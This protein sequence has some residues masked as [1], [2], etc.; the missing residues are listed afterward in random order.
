MPDEPRKPRTPERCHNMLPSSRRVLTRSAL[1]CGVLAATL[2]ACFWPLFRHPADL[3]VGVQ[4]KGFTDLLMFNLPR[5]EYLR[6][7]LTRDG[8]L[9]FWCP[10]LGGGSP[11]LGSLQAA[12]FYPGNWPFWFF[13][14]RGLISWSLVGHHLLAA[15][16]AYGLCRRLGGRSLGASLA[17]VAFGASPVLLARTGEGH[18]VTVS[19]LSW[20]PWTFWMYE[21]FRAGS[22]RG[23]AGLVVVLALAVLAGHLQ[24]AFYLILALT[25]IC[26]VEAVRLAFAGQRARAAGLLA[27]WALAGAATAG[28][29]A[30][31]LIPMA[32]Y[33]RQ[34]AGKARLAGEDLTGVPGVANL[35]QF[36][37]PFA[38]GGPANYRGPGVWYWE[39]ICYFGLVPLALAVLGL[40]VAIQDRRPVGRLAGA[41]AVAF[42]LA[43]G[44]RTPVNWLPAML[45]PGLSMLRCQ[46][47]WVSLTALAVAV[48]AGLGGDAVAS[49]REGRGIGLKRIRWMAGGRLA[50]VLLLAATLGAAEVALAEAWRSSDEAPSVRIDMTSVRD[51]PAPLFAL[52][53]ALGCVILA[54]VLPRRANQFAAL[55]VPIAL[56]ELGAFAA[57]ILRT[58]PAESFPRRNP[59]IETLVQRASGSRV[60]CRQFVIT[61]SEALEHGVM[62]IQ[63]YESVPLDRTLRGLEA[64]F[65]SPHALP[66]MF[67]FEPME[68]SMTS[69]RLLDLWSVR[70][71]IFTS[72][73]PPPDSSMGWKFVSDREVPTILPAKDGE[74]G[75]LPCR[76][77]ENPNVLPRGFVVGQARLLSPGEDPGKVLQGIDPRSQVLLDRDVLPAGPRQEFTPA[78]RVEDTPHR[79]SL[80]VETT[81]PGYLVLA[82]TWYPGWSATV[83]GRLADVLVGDV[84]FRAVALPEPGMHRVVFCYYPA[85]LN[86]GLAISATTALML[87]GLTIRK[88]FTRRR[89]DEPTDA[90]SSISWHKRAKG[91]RVLS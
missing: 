39:T 73:D 38:L 86:L 82:D 67:G 62:K 25:G 56:V 21:E 6:L 59:L 78:R 32:I 40:V 9:P 27:R 15:A 45:V 47:R 71:L 74:P 87:A 89:P 60:L 31:E 54:A 76:V 48:L 55:L 24:E 26:L 57:A 17:A 1:V 7:M 36:I 46:G 63:N 84:T 29:V 23:F 22:R 34:S 58:L 61:D 50:E 35:L 10:W 2:L 8:H 20:Y 12:V 16:G 88:S 30:A 83:D 33:L 70:F 90:W 85:G 53:A 64:A 5:R 43:F 28:L 51:H 65:N 75:F 11:F 41:G 91:T 77:W 80:E 79:V 52:T 68:P 13:D 4:R 72:D 3:L 69:S 37:H 18:L 81:H 66:C 42:I 44:G 19:V 14:A 49:A